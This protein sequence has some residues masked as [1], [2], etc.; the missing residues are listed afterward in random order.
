MPQPNW[1]A[2]IIA[3]LIPMLMGFIYY[4]KAVFGKAWMKSLGLTDADMKGGNMAVIFGVSLLMSFMMSMFLLGNVDGPGQE[5]RYD[6]F[7]HGALHGVIL[8]IMIAVPVLVTNGLFERKNFSN[9]A[10]NALY[11]IITFALMGGVLDAM[12]HW[13]ADMQIPQ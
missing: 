5:G 10:I 9:L 2:V 11:W 12:N 3:A 7:K 1:I 6:S 13:P 4:H 8:G